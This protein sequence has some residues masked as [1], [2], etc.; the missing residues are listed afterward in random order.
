MLQ[1]CSD[2]ITVEVPGEQ[3]RVGY[4][5]ENTDCNNKDVAATLSSVCLDDTPNGMENDFKLSVAFLLP[6]DPVKK[7]GTKRT[8][9]NISSVG[10]G[11]RSD[12]RGGGYV[13]GQGGC[14]GGHGGSQGGGNFK[15]S[16]GN[17]G[18]EFCYYKKSEWFELTDE[19]REE[20]LAHRN[21]NGNYKGTYGKVNEVSIAS[22]TKAGYFTKHQVSSMISQH[23][24]EKENIVDLKRSLIESFK[25]TVASFMV[26]S[27][28]VQEG[29][30]I[31]L[32]QASVASTDV[33]A[34]SEAIAEKRA[35]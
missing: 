24:A 17:T 22:V 5:I 29:G 16:V 19:Q 31:K 28:T 26:P 32:K 33:N 10:G 18:V 6:T 2:H 7:S 21:A 1:R 9:A 14:G 3:T 13:R 25:G 30:I 8:A 4:L 20:L 11:G 35:A 15:A 23:E 12:G 34:D 27:Q